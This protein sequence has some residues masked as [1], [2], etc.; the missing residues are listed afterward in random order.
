MRITPPS[1]LDFG[2]VRVGQTA[3]R[4]I[5]VH[6]DGASVLALDALSL[7]VNPSGVFSLLETPAPQNIAAGQS[8]AFNLRFSPAAAGVVQAN[9]RISSTSAAVTA[10]E[11]PLRGEGSVEQVCTPVSV[12]P[13][14]PANTACSGAP[15]LGQRSVLRIRE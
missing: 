6:N 4:A 13:T 1:P 7:S 12:D 10:V 8:R 14:E 15:D 11:F 3:D 9:L 2:A 5:T